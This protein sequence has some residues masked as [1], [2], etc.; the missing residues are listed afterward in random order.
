MLLT[1]TFDL[2]TENGRSDYNRLLSDPAVIIEKRRLQYSWEKEIYEGEEEFF[3]YLFL[4]IQYSRGVVHD[5][6]NMYRKF[7]IF[8]VGGIDGAG[9][10]NMRQFAENPKHEVLFDL[11]APN[12]ERNYIYIEYYDY[13]AVDGINHRMSLPRSEDYDDNM[14]YDKE[15][16]TYIMK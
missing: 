16:D 6:R 5:L 14:Y 1:A 7:R 3:E 2:F 15:T 13:D 9:H 10:T 12:K 11:S 8:T 4:R